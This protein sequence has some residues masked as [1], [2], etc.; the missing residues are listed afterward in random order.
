MFTSFIGGVRLSD[1]WTKRGALTDA[2]RRHIFRQIANS[3]AQLEFDH[4]GPL[5]FC[6]HDLSYTI[7]NLRKINEGKV[8]HEIGPF[9]TTLSYINEFASSLL[10][11]QG[12]SP[13]EYAYYSVLQLISL[14]LPNQRF[15]GPRF[16]LSP[17]DFDSQNVMVDPHTFNVI[18]FVDWDDVS[19][20]QKDDDLMQN[21]SSCEEPPQVLQAHRDLY[22]AIYAN[23]DPIGAQVTCRSHI[24]EAL[25]IAL[26]HRDL[27][28]EIM[29]K[30]CGYLFGKE[31]IGIGELLFVTEAGD[32]HAGVRRDVIE[33]SG[34]Y[35]I[36][37]FVGG[38]RP[39]H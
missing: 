9:A 35:I 13:S 34:M 4:I 12:Q 25:V 26:E 37:G 22:Y 32:C 7:G 6:G 20:V 17:P 11:E 10:D 36:K 38:Q 16:V 28:A 2:N 14:F 19:P 23:I 1:I 29:S 24:F 3:M 27:S 15:D 33:R 18:R 30:L 5:E 8:V 21:G 39:T 31:Y